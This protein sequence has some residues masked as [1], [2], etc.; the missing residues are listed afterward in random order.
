MFETLTE[1]APDP[2]LSLMA[3]YHADPR[4]EKV[5]LGVG[6]YK[7]D[8]GQTPMMLAVRQA[9]QQQCETQKTKSYLGLLG[10]GSFNQSLA[11]MAFGEFDESRCA[12]MQTPGASGALRLLADLLKQ[13][14]PN[15]CVWLSDPSYVNH[16]PIFRA[17]GCQVAYFPFLDKTTQGLNRD[18]LWA[19]LS[20]V[21]KGDVVLMHGCCHNPTGLSLAPDDWRRFAI[22]AKQR[23]FV[24]FVDLAY[25]GFGESWEADGFGV[26][27]LLAEVEEVAIAYSCSKNFALYRERT[28]LAFLQTKTAQQAQIASGR[29]QTLARQSYTMPPDH[30]ADLVAKILN[31]PNLTTEWQAELTLMRERVQTMR[32]LLVTKISELGGTGFEFIL[33]HQGMFSLTGFNAEQIAYLRSEFAIYLV[34]DGR[35]NFAGLSS[36]QVDW[37]AKAFVAV[38]KN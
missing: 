10:N 13:A 7:D 32:R 17:A 4:P 9:A 20:T 1:S 36:L 21:P 16:A 5:D 24:P 35:M 31:T 33:T 15:V 12:L 11:K 8:S 26:R 30:G 34:G 14:N 37:V 19:T 29:L 28:G 27:H 2:I 6:V 3:M 38:S 22:L 23:G 25:Q 18:G